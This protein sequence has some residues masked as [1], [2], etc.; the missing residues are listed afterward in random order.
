ML[1]RLLIRDFVI[2]DTLEL[3]FPA[4]FGALTGETG[5]GKSILVDALALALGERTDPAVVRGGCAKAEISAEFELGERDKALVW[6][7]SNDFA[8]EESL[9][10]LRRV[11]ESGGR[12][13]G[14]INGAPA[15]IAQMRELGEMLVAIHGQH[16]HHALLRTE[17]QRDLL[18]AHGGLMGLR[19]DVA[20]KY[21]EWRRLA[22][23]RRAAERNAE[24]MVREREML[25]WQLKELVELAFDPLQWEELGT[26]H[27]RLANAANLLAGSAQVQAALEEGEFALISS[28]AQAAQHLS[29]LGEYDPALREV[30]ELVEDARIRLD[31][32]AHLLRRYGEKLDLDPQRLVEVEARLDAVHQMGRKHRTAPAELP[33]IQLAI[34][35]RLAELQGVSD[36]VV[37]AQREEEAK[38][39]FF[40]SAKDLS[41]GRAGIAVRLSQL[42]T[43][44]MQG[45][46]MEG[47]RFE[48]ALEP[49]SEGSLHGLEEVEFR[50]AANANQ[51]LRPLAKVASGGELS[52]IGLAIQVIASAA[53][54]AGTLIFDEVDVGIGGRVAEIV[55]RM[56]RGLGADRQVLCVTHLPQ[57]AAQ[58]SWQWAIAKMGNGGEVTSSVTALDDLGRVEE[59]ARMLGGVAVTATTRRHAR[60]LLASS[61]S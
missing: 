50:V 32:A 43:D 49:Q 37:L 30:A 9:C 3:A 45:L 1:H 35:R 17:S 15:T 48:A 2:V 23:T 4:G 16:A 28:A 18:D 42:V 5:A 19:R 46:A 27:R 36:P 47:G 13:R 38:A 41:N 11:I 6:L 60:E 7:Q 53:G 33:E 61:R 29:A 44:A 12:S 56:L 51:P 58:A 21:R 52:R 59:I 20:E 54:S 55:G 24:G 34:E 39:A 57:V 22:D 10:L 14:Y 8:A 25:D 31:E 26:E 40:A